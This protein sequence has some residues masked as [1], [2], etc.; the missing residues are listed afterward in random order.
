MSFCRQATITDGAFAHLR[1]IHTLNMSGCSQATLTPVGIA[2]LAGASIVC[3]GCHAA[4]RDAVRVLP[5][6][7]S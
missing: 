7:L 4:V 6:S 2:H 1:G 3:F 5:F